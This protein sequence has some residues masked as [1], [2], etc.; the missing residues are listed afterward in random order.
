M[1]N[2]IAALLY[3]FNDDMSAARYVRT[4]PPQVEPVT[5]S[6][7]EDFYRRHGEGDVK[8]GEERVTEDGK[9]DPK[10]YIFFEPEE[11]EVCINPQNIFDLNK[12]NT[13]YER[14]MQELEQ[15]KQEQLEEA[16]KREVFI[17]PYYL[18]GA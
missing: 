13:Q 8:L 1:P 10:Q 7:Y 2:K 18:R 5:R 6:Q 9:L 15:R 12:L 4:W 16:R 14:L 3:E 11:P 17:T